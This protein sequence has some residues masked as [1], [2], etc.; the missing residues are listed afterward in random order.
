MATTVTTTISSISVKPR[1][2][3]VRSDVVARMMS[4]M[5]SYASLF[6]W[7]HSAGVPSINRVGGLSRQNRRRGRPPPFIRSSIAGHLSWHQLL[8]R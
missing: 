6:A 1:C 8:S 3:R 7:P 4:A 5:D 2:A